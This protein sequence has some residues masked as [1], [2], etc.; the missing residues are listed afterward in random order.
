[1]LI[2]DTILLLIFFTIQG[3]ASRAMVTML[4]L[5]TVKGI[6]AIILIIIIGVG[7]VIIIIIILII[8]VVV[9]RFFIT[10]I[11]ILVIIIIMIKIII[12]IVIII[13][14]IIIIIIKIIIIIVIIIIII[15]IIIIDI[16]IIIIIVI[17]ATINRYVSCRNSRPILFKCESTLFFD[18]ILQVITGTMMIAM[19]MIILKIL[20]MMM[21]SFYKDTN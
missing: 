15:V 6:I 7:V 13:L 20:T 14:T 11:I 5:E 21:V 8:I 17:I 4:S 2:F 16:Q 19:I 12:T 3:N 1:M 9:I 18:F 10:F